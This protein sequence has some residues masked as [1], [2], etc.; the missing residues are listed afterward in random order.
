M[1][2]RDFV[3]LTLFVA[4]LIAITPPLGRFLVRVFAGERHSLSRVL[5]PIE[6]S[7]YKSSGV[8]PA[9][10]RLAGPRG[11]VV[12]GVGAHHFLVLGLRDGVDA[13]VER[14]RDLHVMLLLA[15]Q[16]VACGGLRALLTCLRFP[17]KKEAASRPFCDLLPPIYRRLGRAPSLCFQELAAISNRETVD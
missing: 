1:H 15:H 13:Q 12:T 2:A 14:P 9:H 5:G 10:G 6:R 8:D 17:E 4:G 11:G 7:I 3:Q 16:I